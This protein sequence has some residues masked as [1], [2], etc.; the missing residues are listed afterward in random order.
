MIH[1]LLSC[2]P[3][4]ESFAIARFHKLNYD[5]ETMHELRHYEY[6]FHEQMEIIY[7]TNGKVHV[8]MEDGESRTLTPGDI[9]VFGENVVHDIKHLNDDKTGF[10]TLFFSVRQVLKAIA[11][12]DYNDHIYQIKEYAY[13]NTSDGEN[14]AEIAKC[15]EKTTSVKNSGKSGTYELLFGLLCEIIGYLRQLGFISRPTESDTKTTHSVMEAIN[16]ISKNFK[17]KISPKDIADHVYFSVDYLGKV[18]KRATGKTLMEYISFVRIEEAKNLLLTTSMSISDVGA[19]VGFSS[20]SYF[21]RC[22]KK[23]CYVTP[24]IYKKKLIYKQK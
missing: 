24:H 4:N 22:F 7:V 10:F 15:I 9:A 2:N 20:S 3:K 16:Y 23:Y 19:E 21:I 11:G 18:F 1:E 8:T 5:P 12:E 13:Y 14:Q 6:H 17:E